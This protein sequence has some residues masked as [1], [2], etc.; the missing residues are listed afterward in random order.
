MLESELTS[1]RQKWEKETIRSKAR[2]SE[3]L[4]QAQAAEDEL[5]SAKAAA[6][7][8]TQ[9]LNIRVE[10]LK[11]SEARAAKLRNKLAALKQEHHNA[12]TSGADLERIRSE[13]E[14]TITSL[15]ME[16]DELQEQVISLQRQVD[17][18]SGRLSAALAAQG[19]SASR[20]AEYVKVKRENEHLQ[21]QLSKASR[22][23]LAAQKRTLGA[24]STA[25]LHTMSQSLQSPPGGGLQLRTMAASPSLSAALDIA[26]AQAHAAHSPIARKSGL[27]PNVAS[28]G[29]PQG[30]TQH[31]QGQLAALAARQARSAL[32][33]RSEST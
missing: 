26:T 16:N 6:D 24:S 10:E 5:A 7:E 15:R 8:A 9:S 31:S 11:A 20:F 27:L 4:M 32:A 29:T 28:S 3:L 19:K 30:A 12:A 21:S 17:E 33:A 22:A 25:P 1:I 23:T 2:H 18:L 13:L 14:G